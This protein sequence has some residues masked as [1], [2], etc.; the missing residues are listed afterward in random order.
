MTTSKV[1]VLLCLLTILLF[2]A[3]GKKLAT[4]DSEPEGPAAAVQT[5]TYPGVGIVKDLDPKLPMIEIDHEDIR[6]LMPAMQMQFHVKDKAL[7]DGLAVGD[8]IEFTVENGV[9]GLRIVALH[10]V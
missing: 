1:T 7:L 6:G 2:I 4:R 9:G 10:K 3:C 8:R 5:K